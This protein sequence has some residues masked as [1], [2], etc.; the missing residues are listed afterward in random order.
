MA[1]SS[2]TRTDDA[3]GDEIKTITDAQNRHIQVSALADENGDQTGIPANPLVVDGSGVTQPVSAASLPLPSGA[4]TSANQTT[5]NT[6]LAAID[7]N[8]ALS[9]FGTNDVDEASATVT[10]VGKS[11]KDGNWLVQK[12]N[13]TSGVALGWANVSN[14][15]GYLTYSAAWAARASLTYQRFDQAF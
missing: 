12:I 14:N 8:T 7:V 3:S 1:V 11:D 9:K 10:Y 4:A 5:G 6:S 13:T 15:G 2:V